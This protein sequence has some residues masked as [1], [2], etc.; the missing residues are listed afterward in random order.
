MSLK[1]PP[2]FVE[3][4]FGGGIVEKPVGPEVTGPRPPRYTTWMRELCYTVDK[5]I[6]P[7]T[8][9]A[10]VLDY[11]FDSVFKQIRGERLNSGA[12]GNMVGAGL[13]DESEEEDAD[14]ERKRV[15]KQRARSTGRA[16]KNGGMRS[17]RGMKKQATMVK[18]EGLVMVDEGVVEYLVGII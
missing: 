17:K 7:I 4:A 8:Y 15:W 2:K 10:G 11:R 12:R 13:K 6:E 18:Q 14:G 16:R 5:H 3:D 1:N 9:L